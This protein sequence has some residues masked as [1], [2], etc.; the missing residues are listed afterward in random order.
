MDGSGGLVTPCRVD[1]LRLP[2]GAAL[3]PAYR[4]DRFLLTD[5]ERRR[6][7]VVWAAEGALLLRTESPGVA[8]PARSRGGSPGRPHGAGD[9]P[10]R[11]ELLGLADGGGLADLFAAH[12]VAEEA[13]RLGGGPVSSVTVSRRAAA[14]LPARTAARWGLSAGSSWDWMSVDTG[15][16]A[17]EPSGRHGPRERAVPVP[18]QRLDPRA[19][20]DAI[21]A[22]LLRSNPRTGADPS[23]P[24]TAVWW[25]CRLPD[26]SL[27]GVI[28]AVRR[29]AGA[30]PRGSWHLHGLG[31]LPE[32]REAGLGAAL[33]AAAARAGLAGTAWVS[34]G[35]Y[36]D[37][38]RA[39]R[40]YRRLGFRTERELVTFRASRA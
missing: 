26:G 23:A 33:T 18:V 8:A 2:P 25:G 21:R 28:G 30:D 31:V 35:L 3:P 17:L 29:A 10:G 15:T 27:G 4:T 38:D 5:P 36:A 32:L 19:D 9:P 14:D 1:G 37:N 22:C 20:A 24:G 13:G 12:E 40:V 6:G 7:D 11:A 34:L 39:R 16:A